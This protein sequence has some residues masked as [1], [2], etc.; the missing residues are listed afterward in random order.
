MVVSV[1]MADKNTLQISQHF[2]DIALQ[3]LVD[4]ELTD[5]LTPSPFACIEKDVT[6]IR[7]LHQG[8][9]H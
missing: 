6:P 9:R 1:Y 4:P 5:K 2:P 3:R 7:D 8:S